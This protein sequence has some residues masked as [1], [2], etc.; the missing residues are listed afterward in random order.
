MGIII[1]IHSLTLPEAPVSFMLGVTRRRVP[2]R[3]VCATVSGLRVK[4][5]GYHGWPL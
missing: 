4:G 1:G 5:L 2:F 3:D